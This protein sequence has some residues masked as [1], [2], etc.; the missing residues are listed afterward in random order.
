MINTVV[1]KL[2]KWTRYAQIKQY[3][4]QNN[5]TT[6]EKIKEEID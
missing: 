2:M 1:D 4:L 3:I 5:L 6:N